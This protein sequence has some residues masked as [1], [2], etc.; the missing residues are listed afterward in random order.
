MK[1]TSAKKIAPTVMAS[2]SLLQLSN[3]ATLLRFV[4]VCPRGKFVPCGESVSP[5]QGATPKRGSPY[6]KLKGHTKVR[7]SVS[8]TQ[9]ATPKCGCPYPQLKG[10][11]QSVGVWKCESPYPQQSRE[12][13][14]KEKRKK[15]KKGKKECI[16][17]PSVFAL[18]STSTSGA[19][20]G[21]ELLRNPCVLG[22]S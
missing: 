10:P 1:V 11:R 9:G 14:K 16:V 21:A 2:L 12:H 7:E 15:Q 20:K 19:Q 18:E 5:T 13:E 6:P 17:E 4:G 22:G 8:P 3:N